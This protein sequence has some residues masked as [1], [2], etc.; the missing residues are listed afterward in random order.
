MGRMRR[1]E[2]PWKLIPSITATKE[3]AAYLAYALKELWSNADD[4]KIYHRN[5]E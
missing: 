1:G 4:E 3:E 5:E 2:S